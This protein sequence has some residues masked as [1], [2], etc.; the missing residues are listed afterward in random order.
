MTSQAR[1]LRFLF[2]CRGSASDGLGHVV[3]TRAVIEALPRGA[4]AE[5]VVIGDTLAA[6]LLQGLP[7]EW[8]LVEDER[9]V[10]PRARAL[11][12]DIVVLDL[13]S[14][15]AAVF[16]ELGAGTVTVSLSPIFSFLDK[17]DLA[18]SR[19]S[20]AVDGAPDATHRRYG[21]AYAI[22]R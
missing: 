10:A 2:V 18:F 7:I 11:A 1:A 16:D 12:P 14:L 6:G 22:V 20:Y 13:L 8:T 3:R 4:V 19:T 15:E 9:L 21:L 17:V 5:L